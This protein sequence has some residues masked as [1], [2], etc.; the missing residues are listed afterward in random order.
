[1]EAETEAIKSRFFSLPVMVA[2][3]IGAQMI[4]LGNI[5]CKCNNP[6]LK[7][8]IAEF[9]GEVGMTALERNEVGDYTYPVV[10]AEVKARDGTKVKE[11]LACVAPACL[12]EAIKQ[13]SEEDPKLM[14]HVRVPVVPLE[15]VYD[16]TKPSD[17][18]ELKA[19][20]TGVCRGE[21][22]REIIGAFAKYYIIMKAK[23]DPKFKEKLVNWLRDPTA[24]MP[25]GLAEELLEYLHKLGI[26][27]RERAVKD[28]LYGIHLHQSNA[29]LSALDIEVKP[30][31]TPMTTTCVDYAYVQSLIKKLGATD[32]GAAQRYADVLCILT[33][34]E[35]E[36]LLNIAEGECGGRLK[37]M[38][39]RGASAEDIRSLITECTEPEVKEVESS[40]EEGEPV[41][42]AKPEVR[43]KAKPEVGAGVTA[44]PEAKAGEVE[45]ELKPRTLIDIKVNCVGPNADETDECKFVKAATDFALG[46]SPPDK[47]L[48]LFDAIAP[49][50]F[51]E[52]TGEDFVAVKGTINK[53]LR[54][55]GIKNADKVTE[56]YTL[57]GVGGLLDK[58]LGGDIQSLIEYFKVVIEK[59]TGNANDESKEALKNLHALL[60]NI[61]QL[62]P[63]ALNEYVWVLV[64]ATNAIKG[65]LTWGTYVAG[66]A[67]QLNLDPE[68]VCTRLAEA[69]RRKGD[70]VGPP[71]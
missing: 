44:E 67:T 43:L 69:G 51:P 61:A 17:E 66:L 8:S 29:L 11:A 54:A 42:A 63:G 3:E 10:L 30:S 27:V 31:P 18:L 68:D 37:S 9:L 7:K 15:G 59:A 71:Y 1:M 22:N 64:D 56:L 21:G 2:T 53:L 58:A 48:Q 50:K 14:S 33:K 20:I 34:S 38:L 52:P 32:M 35:L 49:T 70:K 12:C 46:R 41:E 6:E 39:E 62:D 4:D 19:I 28:A 55:Y 45:F 25:Y 16:L 36:S 60:T 65:R 13:L 57:K 5:A 26:Y 24:N 40:I 23:E 47:F